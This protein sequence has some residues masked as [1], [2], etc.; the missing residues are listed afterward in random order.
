MTV[1]QRIAVFDPD[2][3][4]PFRGLVKGPLSNL[5]ELQAIERFIRAVVLHDQML[6]ELEPHAYDPLSDREFTEEEIA[7]G[8]QNVI[9]AFGPVIDEY[10]LFED[11]PRN[12]RQG[13]SGQLSP[14]LLEKAKY[15]SN[16][17]VGKVYYEAHVEYLQ[18]LIAVV[19]N[20]GS[21]VCDG[22]VST[23]TL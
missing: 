10:G 16:A 7:A 5:G 17:G 1:T 21:L 6:M 14:E 20:G 15:L 18:R 2:A 4:Y 11:I 19:Q 9:V 12:Q 8:G 13:F 23:V 3:F 22:T